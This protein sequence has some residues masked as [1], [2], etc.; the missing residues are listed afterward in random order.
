MVL[1]D[2]STFLGKSG[3]DST[4]NATSPTGSCKTTTSTTLL[5]INSWQNHHYHQDLISPF[6]LFYTL[7]NIPSEKEVVFFFIQD[8]IHHSHALSLWHVYGLCGILYV[9]YPVIKVVVVVRKIVWVYSFIAD[10][11]IKH[12]NIFLGNPNSWILPWFMHSE[13]SGNIHSM[14]DLTSRKMECIIS[15]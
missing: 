15:G 14:Q 4:L 8:D 7:M 2:E 12:L 3:D 9:R 6:N 11:V 1:E 13:N 5:N 10:L